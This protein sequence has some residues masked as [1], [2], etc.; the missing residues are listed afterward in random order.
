M[1]VLHL[2]SDA[3]KLKVLQ[4]LMLYWD[5]QW[6]LKVVDRYGLEEA[7]ALNRRVRTAFGRI[8]MR[9]MLQALR[10]GKGD[11]RCEFVIT[12]AE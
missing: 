5:G 10:L 8:E 7:I 3:A 1:A 2:L 11:A 9:T 12:A 6:Y 4:K